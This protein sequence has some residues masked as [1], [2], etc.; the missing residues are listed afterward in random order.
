MEKKCNDEEYGKI[1]YYIIYLR[2][3]ML[4]KFMNINIYKF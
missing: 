3:V 2:N 4:F 1:M